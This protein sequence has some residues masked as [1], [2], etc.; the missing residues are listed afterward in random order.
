MYRSSK[1]LHSAPL[2]NEEWMDCSH[3]RAVV[4][5][6]CQHTFISKHHVKVDFGQYV[7]FNKWFKT[8]GK[9]K[10]LH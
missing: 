3:C 7:S 6:H 9:Y 2:K 10:K 8:T 1:I 4:F 5:T